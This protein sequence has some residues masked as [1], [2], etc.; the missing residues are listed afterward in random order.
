[1][2]KLGRIFYEQSNTFSTLRMFEE[3]CSIGKVLYWDVADKIFFEIVNAA[4][5]LSGDDLID[6][7]TYDMIGEMFP[8]LYEDL[9]E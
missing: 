9:F 8:D 2:R 6:N 3:D 1:M 5:N 7:D 4:I